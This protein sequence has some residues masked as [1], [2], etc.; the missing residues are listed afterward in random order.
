ME[1]QRQLKFARLIQRDLSEIFREQAGSFDA[2]ALI[3]VTLVKISPDLAIASVYL[4]FYPDTQEQFILGNIK[5]KTKQ[6]R[7]TLASKIRNQV[8][9]IPE[10]RFFADDTARE[11]AR[12]DALIAG[13][14]IPAE[15]K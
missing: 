4:S 3:T 9:V 5:D 13:L 2:K 12:I 6:I 1:S 7:Q 14:D 10:L 11:A 15:E 8:R